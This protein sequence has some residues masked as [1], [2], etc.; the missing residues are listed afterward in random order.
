MLEFENVRFHYRKERPI[1][2]GVDFSVSEGEFV[3]IVGRNGC[4][5]STLARL[6]NGLVQPREGSIRVNGLNPA[7]DADLPAIRRQVGLIF[8]NPD[9][10]FI[11][12]TVTDEMIFGLEN[13]WVPREQIGE[14]VKQA[15]LDVD[16]TA[17]ADAAPHELSGG[18]KQRAAVAAV[19]AMRP[20]AVI[21]DEAT[22][23]LDPQGRARMTELMTTLHKQGMTIVH[24]T[25]HMDEVMAAERVLLLDQGQIAFDGTPAALFGSSLPEAH[26][27]E[28]PFA[29]RVHEALGWTGTPVFDWKERARSQWTTSS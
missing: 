5:K 20:R 18:Q 17:Y 25:H 27:L 26:G 3:C 21:F 2:R 23:M 11:T 19:L 6:M 28:K 13:I 24:I 15:L 29:V 16:L 9:D 14:R 7:A 8:Q 12:Q 4:G 22:S 10:Q 1:L